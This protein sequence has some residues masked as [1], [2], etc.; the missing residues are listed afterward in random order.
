MEKAVTIG[1]GMV[2]GQAQGYADMSLPEFHPRRFKRP[3]TPA[4]LI[5]DGFVHAVAIVAGLIAF[6][7]LFVRI[8]SQGGVSDAVAMAIYA[9][10][11]F[12]LFGFSCAYNMTPPSDTKWLLRR[13]D[14]ASIY[15]M[16][17][18]TYTAL[19]SQLPDRRL[20]WT[21]AGVV[22][23][24]SLGGVALKLLLPGRFDRASIVVYLALGWVAVVAIRQ[25]IETLPAE[26]LILIVV[27]G[28]FYSVGV[29][30]Y[31]WHSL[32]FQNAIWHS[33]VTIAAGCQFA[34]IAQAV[35]HGG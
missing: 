28:L 13:L 8:V 15:L 30:F 20:A 31:R 16:I 27:G 33:F 14:H 17:S 3:Y 24:V 1:C 32:K 9:L 29:L 21:L 6:A 11:F 22:W 10:G 7:V 25:L 12:L 35:G 4:E 23:A 5:A 18:G 34:G 26:T 2:L 19:L